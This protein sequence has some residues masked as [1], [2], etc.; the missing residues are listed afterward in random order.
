MRAVR[1][2]GDGASAGAG[3]RRGGEPKRRRVRAAAGARLLD[4]LVHRL[5]V[6]VGLLLVVGR[7]ALA[8]VL[9]GRA[10]GARARGGGRGPRGGRLG[11]QGLLLAGDLR[12]DAVAPVQLLEEEL[13][14]LA[15]LRLLRGN[16][17]GADDASSRVE[18]ERL[19]PQRMPTRIDIAETDSKRPGSH[20]SPENRAP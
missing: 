16:F 17:I 20:S 10:G 8:R 19:C 2:R 4:V 11:A 9:E 7:A 3:E 18:T 15:N 5:E 13:P 14:P 1:G 6:G 12:A